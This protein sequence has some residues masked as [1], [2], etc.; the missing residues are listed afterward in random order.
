VIKDI[1]A[2]GT[3]WKEAAAIHSAVNR[4]L[5]NHKREPVS[6]DKILRELVNLHES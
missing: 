4:A 3:S 6:V 2:A 5:R 1:G